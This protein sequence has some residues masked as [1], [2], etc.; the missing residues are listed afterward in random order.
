MSILQKALDNSETVRLP[1]SEES[2]ESQCKRIIAAMKKGL[3]ISTLYAAKKLGITS[4]H[5]RLTDIRR[6]YNIEIQSE[7]YTNENGTRYKRYFIE[8]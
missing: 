3:K 1:I 2:R 8:S 5:R 6:R 4:F 7:W